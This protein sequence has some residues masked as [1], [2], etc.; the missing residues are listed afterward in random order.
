MRRE[1]WQR[2]SENA[3]RGGTRA[4]ATEGG[5]ALRL[6]QDSQVRERDDVAA[7]GQGFQGR[8]VVSIDL[9]GR[10][11]AVEVEARGVTVIGANQ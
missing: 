5:E 10:S 4:S 3:G 1:F 9:L 11:V 2:Q 8:A 7:V 6:E